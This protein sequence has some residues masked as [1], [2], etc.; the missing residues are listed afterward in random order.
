[1]EKPCRQIFDIALTRLGIYERD[2][3]VHG[4]WV[5]TF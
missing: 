1:M 2:A 4:K 5:S 3:A